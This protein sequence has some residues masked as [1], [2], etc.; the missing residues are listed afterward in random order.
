MGSQSESTWR[1]TQLGVLRWIPG[2]RCIWLSTQPETA[3][4]GLDETIGE[5]LPSVFSTL[6]GT[7][8]QGSGLWL[9]SVAIEVMIQRQPIVIVQPRSM[10]TL[11]F[12]PGAKYGVQVPEL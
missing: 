1:L 12:V 2:R 10:Q 7:S 9:T 5:T 6:E 4:N 11:L 3:A 8:S